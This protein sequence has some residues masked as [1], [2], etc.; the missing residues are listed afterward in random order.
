MTDEAN[1]DLIQGALYPEEEA[2]I[3]NA[4]HNRRQEFIAGRLCAR[5]AL[6]QLAGGDAPIL[7]GQ[8]G[9]PV[10]PP[11]IVGS[12]SHTAGYCGVAVARKTEIDSVALDVE[13]VGKV[14]RDCW[15]EVCTQQELSWINSLPPNV[16]QEHVAL[17]FSAKE[18][19]Y[20]CQYVI[21]QRRLDFHDMTIFL[22]AD[23]NEFMMRTIACARG[24]FAKEISFKGRYLF[25]SGYVF[26][27]MTLRRQ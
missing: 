16:R 6:A 3:C 19:F 2:L 7:M 1:P 26:T 18:C 5:R 20:K 22:E 13:C 27:G 17:T 8:E 24:R 10:W 11:G 14:D 25:H 12:I 9:A 4:A 21:S 23:T 15:K